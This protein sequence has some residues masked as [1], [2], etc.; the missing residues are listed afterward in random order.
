LR[1]LRRRSSDL[2]ALGR[3]GYHD[4]KDEEV[5]RIVESYREHRGQVVH[6]L[7]RALA[8]SSSLGKTARYG[9]RRSRSRHE[10]TV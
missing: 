6:D 8:L 1:S 3:M 2:K 9:V 7:S 10:L 4:V 5:A